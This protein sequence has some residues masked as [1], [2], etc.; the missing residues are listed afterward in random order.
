MRLWDL[1]TGKEL[2]SFPHG[3]GLRHVVFTPDGRRALS[4]NDGATLRLWDLASGKELHRYRHD[5][6]LVEGVAASRDGRYALTGGYDRTMRLWRLP[7]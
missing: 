1:A 3:T 6:G 2:R 5:W 4:G 7:R